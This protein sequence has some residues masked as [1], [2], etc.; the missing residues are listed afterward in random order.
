M[1]SKPKIRFYTERDSFGVEAAVIL[2]S[3]SIIFRLIGTWGLWSNREFLLTQVALPVGSA[4][5]FILL[6]LLLGRVALWS[7][8][9][10]V[11]AGVV[12]FIL[13]AFSFED[14][15][16]LVLCILLYVLAAVLWCGTVFH[17]IRT[18]WLLPPLFLLPFLYH[19]LV[20]DLKA[21]QN[22]AQPVTFADGMQEMSVLC[23][24]L[25]LFFASLAIKK[26]YKETP[27]AE[28]PPVQPQ[29]E[30]EPASA[31]AAAPAAPTPAAEAPAYEPHAAADRPPFPQL[32]LDPDET[33]E[34]P[35]A[36]V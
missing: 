17:L 9:L 22:T 1:Q 2:L 30:S 13:K 11:L 25:A 32:T 4:L 35:S 31:P 6:L 34:G 27:A 5:L 33:D 15:M 3:L 20:V 26:R 7:T 14:K 18:K 16:Q 23:I 19:V 21:L 12:F 29:P 24:M 36:P 10:P 28:Q 8:S